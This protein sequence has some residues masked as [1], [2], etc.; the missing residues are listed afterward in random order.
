[1]ANALQDAFRHGKGSTGFFQKRADD[2]EARATALAHDQTKAGI[3][4]AAKLNKAAAKD[5]DK[6]AATRQSMEAQL[7][8]INANDKVEDIADI[9]ARF[10]ERKLRERAG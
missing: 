7:E 2:G 9:A 6:A 1:M 5:K 3:A 8:K 10:N 4:Q